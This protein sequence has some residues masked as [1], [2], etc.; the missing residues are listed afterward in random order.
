M[1]DSPSVLRKESSQARSKGHVLKKILDEIKK[2]TKRLEDPEAAYVCDYDLKRIWE[3]ES[4]I[5][6][7]V[8]PICLS[9]IEI[10]HIQENMLIILSTLVWIGAYACLSDFTHRL[11]TMYGEPHFVD[12]DV[13]L[14][15]EQLYFLDSEPALQDQ[16]YDNQFRFKPARI[17]L[18]PVEIT[19]QLHQKARLPFETRMEDV[20]TGG[21]GDVDCVGISPRYIKMASGWESPSVSLVPHSRFVANSAQVRFVACKKVKFHKD[22]NQEKENLQILKESLTSHHRIMKHLTTIE[23]GPNW[24]ILLPYAPYGDL[25][26]FL[27]C[28]KPPLRPQMY[29]FSI[30]FS[31]LKSI[32]ATLPLLAEC[33]ALAHALYFLHKDIFVE[34]TSTTVFCA[35]MDLKPAN[36]LIHHVDGSPVGQWVITDFGISVFKKDTHEL[37]D[38]VVSIGDYYSQVT[39]NTRPTRQAGTYQAPEVTIASG[40]FGQ[41]TRLTPEQRGIGRK[42]D[43]W[44]FGC[45][46]SEVLAFSVGKDGLVRKFQAARTKGHR[47]DYFYEEFGQHLTATDMPKRYEI[48][49]SVVSWLQ[50]LCHNTA[51]PQRWVDC[52]VGTIMKILVVDT[53]DRPMRPNSSHCCNI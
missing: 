22:F 29:D 50:D 53:K 12:G 46:L 8:D 4:R 36:I 48:R 21:Y 42:S 30:Q 14:K 51:N 28:G 20:G 13:P 10:R 26:V 18:P 1:S 38:K 7:V 31:G 17:I 39:M 52:Y 19:Q 33:L 35:H 2:A 9:S 27:H 15:K 45:I 3:D 6:A 47:D 16:F 23:H 24:Y 41:R 11:F 32:D 40:S 44:S 43:I 34:K 25:E 49:K 5:R 37:D